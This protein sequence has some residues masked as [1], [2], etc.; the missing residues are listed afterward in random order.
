MY[1]YFMPPQHLPGA[2]VVRAGHLAACV[3]LIS[4]VSASCYAMSIRTWVDGGQY[5]F[6]RYVHYSRL[7][8]RIHARVFAVFLEDHRGSVLIEH[9][10]TLH[11]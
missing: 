8:V 10:R 3:N 5:V 9:A 11:C 2:L 7:T 4:T 1:L 6:D